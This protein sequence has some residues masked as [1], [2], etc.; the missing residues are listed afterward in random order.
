M[1]RLRMNL[2]P[3]VAFLARPSGR[4]A[5]LGRRGAGREVPLPSS[6]GVHHPQV[7]PLPG[8]PALLVAGA[9]EE[10][11]P[12]VGRPS[13]T[14]ERVPRETQQ[15]ASVGVD[16]VDGEVVPERDPPPVRRPD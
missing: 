6:V 1:T 12:P 3:L 4:M 5:V 15:S 7:S 8:G 14:L 9:D 10:E 11:F 16:G 2:E 13:R